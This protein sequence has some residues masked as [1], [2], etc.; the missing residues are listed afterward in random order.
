MSKSTIDTA[1]ELLAENARLQARVKE[2]EAVVQQ[3]N[4]ECD[5]LI[6]EKALLSYNAA[7]GNPP[8]AVVPPEIDGRVAYEL[9]KK[10]R[11]FNS[12]SDSALVGYN[13]CREDTIALS[14]QPVSAAV[15]TDIIRDASRYRFLRD[16]DAFGA[17]NEEGLVGWDGLSELD[18]NEFDAAIDARMNHPDAIIPFGV[19][20]SG[21]P[22]KF[23]V[24]LAKGRL[25]QMAYETD[26]INADMYLCIS[27]E[28]AIEAIKAAGGEVE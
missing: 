20:L 2:L 28:G 22:H 10:Y 26:P 8:A 15:P 24:K 19:P 3:R 5:R 17:D 11:T 9:V 18:T 16:A 21:Q 23:V 14:G 4:S 7:P 6:I 27:R 13:Q 1:N 12:A 25:M